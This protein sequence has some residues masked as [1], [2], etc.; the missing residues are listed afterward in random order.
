MDDLETHR[1]SPYT[2]SCQ[3]RQSSRA[4]KENHNAN[5]ALLPQTAAK[6]ELVFYPQSWIL[7]FCC[8]KA[9]A[10]LRAVFARSANTA[11]NYGIILGVGASGWPQDPTL[12][13]D[14][15]GDA[16]AKGVSPSPSNVRKRIFCF[17]RKRPIFNSGARNV[18]AQACTQGVL[19]SPR[20][21][22]L[23]ARS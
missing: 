18:A 9:R 2:L 5:H 16:P 14:I 22:C 10:K 13:F 4:P 6:A 8:G 15:G 17:V 20:V 1:A 7:W 21:P 19:C 11:R 3:E 12:F 23:R